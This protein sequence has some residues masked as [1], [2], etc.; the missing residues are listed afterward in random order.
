MKKTYHL[1]LSGK[2]EVMFR[3]REDFIRGINCLCLAACKTHSSLLAYSFMSNHVHFLIQS[4]SPEKFMGAFR[5]PYS[6]Y[7]NNKYNRAGKLG[8]PHHF[9]LEIKGHHHHLA[10]ISYILRNALHHGVVGIPYAYPYSSANVIFQKEMGKSPVTDLLPQKSFYRHIG[11]RVSFPDS[12]KMSRSGLFLR[13]SVLDIPQV[14]NLFMTPR[15]FDYYM[16][17]RTSEDW[18]N[19]QK[20][21]GNNS[22]LI[23]LDNIEYQTEMNSIKQMLINEGGRSDYQKISDIKL[24]NEIDRITQEEFGKSSI[25]TLTPSEKNQIIK[26]I[27]SK[28]YPGDEQIHRCLAMDYL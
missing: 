2:H 16:S 20:K 3:C 1:C 9:T 19:E 24:C 28:Y 4:D 27:R 11:R 13:E 22:P 14:E 8:E 18:T 7:F 15:A 12:Y 26:L 17:R 10:A 5:M 6:K 23:T 21:D 25:Y